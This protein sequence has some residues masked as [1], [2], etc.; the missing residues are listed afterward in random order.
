MSLNSITENSASLRCSLLRV[1][2]LLCC[3]LLICGAAGCATIEVAATPLAHDAFGKTVLV[4]PLAER[5]AQYSA[6]DYTLFGKTGTQGSGPVVARAVARALA[7]EGVA[8]LVSREAVRKTMHHRNLKMPDL[9]ALSVHQGTELS[10]DLGAEIVVMG[11]VEAYQT[12]WFLFV[13]RSVV[14]FSLR[15]LETENGRGIWRARFR[16]G[17]FFKNERRLTTEGAKEIA[18]TLR[19]R[20]AASQTPPKP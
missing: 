2:G 6:V 19:S 18:V 12:A 17:S 1:T 16:K 20:F 7:S 13:P 15:A 4:L 11:E 9:A 8:R 14:A 5:P 3:V 10:R